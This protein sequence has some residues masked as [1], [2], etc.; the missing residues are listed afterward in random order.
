VQKS[1]QKKQPIS[2]RP[3]D[4]PPPQR[5]GIQNPFG[6]DP[7]RKIEPR[8]VVGSKD[9]WSE[10]TLADGSIISAKAVILDVKRA[11]DQYSQDGNPLYILQ[12]AFVNR[13]Q[14]PEVLKKKG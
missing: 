4:T 3:P 9:G 7:T 2:N 10:Y 8:D 13:V 5:A 14:A 6:Y 12:F 11:V 1:K